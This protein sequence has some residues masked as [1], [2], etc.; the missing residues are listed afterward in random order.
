LDAPVLCLSRPAFQVWRQLHDEVEVELSR[1]GEFA[2]VPDFGSKIGENAAR[3]AANFHVITQG[4]GGS[5]CAATMEG[6]A[7]VAI[8]HL[9]EARRILGSTKTPED[10]ADAT[11][12]FEWLSSREASDSIEPRDILRLGPPQLRDKG[13]RDAAIKIL[14]AKNWGCIVTVGNAD[15]FVL[16]PKTRP[17][18]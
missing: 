4:P 18:S 17:V 5:I 3:I 9:N 7:A 6:A 2:G 1:V 16:N 13:R 12:L 15:R 10:I 11:L 8:W 14:A